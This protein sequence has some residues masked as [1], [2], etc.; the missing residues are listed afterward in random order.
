VSPTATG[1]GIE[2]PATDDRATAEER[3]PLPKAVAAEV[4]DELFV[5]DMLGELLSGVPHPARAITAALART[6]LIE[7]CLLMWLPLFRDPGST[8]VGSDVP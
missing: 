5:D 7:G 2:A 6:T 8:T 1:Y 3:T 4:C